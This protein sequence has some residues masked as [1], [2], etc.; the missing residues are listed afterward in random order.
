M[1]EPKQETAATKSHTPTREVNRQPDSYEL[2]EGL[3]RQLEPLQVQMPQLSTAPSLGTHATLLRRIA[4]SQRGTTLLQMQRQYGN[5]Y[6]Q[7]VVA[8]SQAEEGKPALTP[9]HSPRLPIQAKLTVSHPNDPYEQ[10]ADHVADAVMH[11]PELTVERQPLKPE[12]EEPLQR[13]GPV[14]DTRQPIN[15]EEEE[16]LQRA[17]GITDSIEVMP[18]T[19][20]QINALRGQGQPLP[21]NV[22]SFMEPRF[23]A[24][25]S[26]V[27]VHTDPSAGELAQRIQA[28]AFT[29][30]QDV[31]FAPGQYAPHSDTGKHLLAHELTH[32]VQQGYSGIHPKTQFIPKTT[33]GGDPIT[34]EL[35]HTIWQT[36]KYQPNVQRKLEVGSGLKLDTMG[37]TTTK[38]GDAYTCPAIVKK[39]GVWNEIFT[40]LLFSPRVFKIDGTSNAQINSNLKKHMNARHGIVVFASQKRYTFGA[41]SAFRMN[42]DYWL[43]GSSGWQP[44][45]G[46]DRD[47][48]IKD[49]NVHPEKYSIACLAATQ[50]TMEGG[51]KSSLI[52]DAGGGTEDWIPGDWGYITNTA[53][54]ATG[55]IVGQEGENIIY[56]GNDK[57]WGHYGPGNTYQTLTEWFDQVKGWNGSANIEDQR[58]RPTIGLV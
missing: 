40:S 49:L 36:G 22:R 15:P 32:V 44:K 53:F 28:Q 25:F 47:K 35:T 33:M 39:S 56:T 20:T 16:Q 6:V 21:D 37:F 9:A 5:Q 55:G 1:H 51:S 19:E 14:A 57:F 38:V 12:D 7:R 52:G 3:E 30:G 26:Q 41:G 31:V 34:H 2:Q 50:L 11:Q 43:V 46:V 8:L 42:P 13:A 58:T 4:E 48:A 18:E 10:E 27:R 29:V 54:P 24:D 23:G 17:G 45:P